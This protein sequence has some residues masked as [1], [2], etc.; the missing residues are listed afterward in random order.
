MGVLFAY[1]LVASLVILML[2][3]VLHQVVNR[4]TRFSFNRKI[5]ICCILLAAISPLF[6]KNGIVQV[7]I[8]ISTVTE[9]PALD[10]LK[11]TVNIGISPSTDAGNKDNAAIW[12][13]WVLLFYSAGIVILLSREAISLLRIASMICKSEKRDVD[14]LTI[15]RLTDTAIAP[16]SWGNYIFM[17]D[18]ERDETTGSIYLHEKAHTEKRH[19]IDVLFV[20]VFC[21]F[22]WY[23]PFAWL[24]RQL[25]RLNHEFEADSKVLDSGIS[26][27][28]YQHLLI[29][30]AIGRR[31]IPLV[32]SFTSGKNSFRKRVL[33]MSKKRSSKWVPFI[34]IGVIPAIVI[35]LMIV[36][37]PI[38][39][40]ILTS[41]KNDTM[42][43]SVLSFHNSQAYEKPHTAL[44][45]SMPEFIG[46]KTALT[47]FIIENIMYPPN[48]ADNRL[49]E[50]RLVNVQFVIDQNGNVVDAHVPDA[51]NDKYEAEALRIIEMTSGKWHPAIIDGKAVSY[52]LSLPIT[53]SH[54]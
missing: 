38:S 3:P 11:D 53:F 49:N 19:W 7:P 32:N 43:E 34:A 2:Y 17:H 24:T 6:M 30:K 23:N 42:I 5:L 48:Q 54:M 13:A 1:S 21:I 41:V 12:I 45:E 10:A 29:V 4:C 15:C 36:S 46:G 40:E 47:I 44:A 50:P 26:T 51:Q 28:D 35:S 18:S 14:G 20:D 33:I 8:D 39:A 31:A 52:A 27:Y 37:L 9:K 16:F 25:V 22:Q